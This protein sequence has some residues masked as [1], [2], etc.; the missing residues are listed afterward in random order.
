MKHPMQIGC[1]SQEELETTL[2]IDYF[3]NSFSIYTNVK[4][5][6]NLLRERFP[7]NFSWRLASLPSFY[8]EAPDG[9]SATAN[10]VPLK[11]LTFV[12]LSRL[13]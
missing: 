13:S 10:D 9:A 12:S 3:S 6:S 5:V 11:Q 2:T 1:F 8:R 4:S 7:T